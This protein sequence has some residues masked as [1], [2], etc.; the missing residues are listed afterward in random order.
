VAFNTAVLVGKSGI[1]QVEEP[2]WKL[3]PLPGVDED[4][5]P[6]CIV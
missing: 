5:F 1:V 2:N 4:N 3:T 6:D